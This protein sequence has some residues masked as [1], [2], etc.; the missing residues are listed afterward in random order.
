MDS[1]QHHSMLLMRQMDSQTWTRA[2]VSS[3]IIC[4]EIWWPK[5]EVLDSIQVWGRGGQLIASVSSSNNWVTQKET[6][7]HRT[8]M[9]RVLLLG[10]CP[11]EPNPKLSREDNK[12]AYTKVPS[13][14]T[15]ALFVCAFIMHVF[16]H[17]VGAAPI[18]VEETEQSS[19]FT[20]KTK[21]IVCSQEIFRWI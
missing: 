10:C 21:T 15:T 8:F 2:S 14:D 13:D 4:G 9:T 20:N 11:P 7:A 17:S 6:R 18:K 16:R 1:L 12:M 3:R 5:Q 19:I